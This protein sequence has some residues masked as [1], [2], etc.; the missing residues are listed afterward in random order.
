M[1]ALLLMTMLVAVGDTGDDLAK[2]VADAVIAHDEAKL[3]G[4]ASTFVRSK[5]GGSTAWIALEQTTAT[6]VIAE[7]NSC[8]LSKV[9]EARIVRDG[10]VSQNREASS[11]WACSVEANDYP[12]D[13]PK[14]AHCYDIGYVLIASP[15]RQ[16]LTL[17]LLREDTWSASRCGVAPLKAMPVPLQKQ[18]ATQTNG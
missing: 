1:N 4:I 8:H 16:R 15:E 11:S 9:I 18:E 17:A 6:T 3:S 5:R 7:L 10:P 12:A 2:R 14:R 13:D